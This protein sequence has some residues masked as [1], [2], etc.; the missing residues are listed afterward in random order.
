[1]AD[2]VPLL[3]QSKNTP[4]DL[5][6]VNLSPAEAASRKDI[7]AWVLALPNGLAAPYA[8]AIRAT[9]KNHPVL[10][11]LS[12]DYRFDDAWTYGFPERFRKEISGSRLVANPG[13]YATGAQASILPFAKLLKK[14][15]NPTVFGVSGYS[16]AGTNPSDKND[17]VKLQDNLMAYPQSLE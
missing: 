16:G 8:D 13:C 15:S 12:A 7:D 5:S 10:V 17:Q 14:G 3:L 6:Y 2:T 11:D 4:H 9:G 1:V